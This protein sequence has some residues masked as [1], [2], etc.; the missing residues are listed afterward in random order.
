MV[1]RQTNNTV[2]IL[3]LSID[4]NW[5]RH[6]R[7]HYCLI[8]FRESSGKS[9]RGQAQHFTGVSENII[10]TIISYC[11]N[12]CAWHATFLLKNAKPTERFHIPTV[13][14]YRP[15]VVFSTTPGVLGLRVEHSPPEN[16]IGFGRD[17][18]FF[19]IFRTERVILVVLQWCWFFIS[20]FFFCFCKPYIFLPEDVIGSIHSCTVSGTKFRLVGTINR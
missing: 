19:F 3:Y 10:I 11:N 4:H 8:G 20:F 18:I 9:T 17:G 7:F 6:R 2:G 14:L 15:G 1:N 12:S 16:N 13:S 5:F